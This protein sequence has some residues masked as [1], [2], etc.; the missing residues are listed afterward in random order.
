MKIKCLHCR[1]GYGTLVRLN[2]S[3]DIE[4]VVCL[5]CLYTRHP[6]SAIEILEYILDREQEDS[7]RL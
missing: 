1:K 7:E 2:P 5:E 3:K 4:K 6:K